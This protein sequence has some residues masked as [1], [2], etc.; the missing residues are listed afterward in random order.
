[1]RDDFDPELSWEFG[2]FGVST[3]NRKADEWSFP[4]GHH[5]GGWTDEEMALGQIVEIVDCHHV[6]LTRIL[7]C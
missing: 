6:Y 4:I 3:M 5:G 2:N 7:R 1:M